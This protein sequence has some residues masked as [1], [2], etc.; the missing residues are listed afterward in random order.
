VIE[1]ADERRAV[2]RIPGLPNT[3]F[4]C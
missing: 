1:F 4:P 3:G 2:L